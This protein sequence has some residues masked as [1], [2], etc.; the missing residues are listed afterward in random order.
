MSE[1][2]KNAK[3]L[4]FETEIESDK[5]L[6]IK[7]EKISF[8]KV[9]FS[10]ILFLTSIFFCITIY[11]S[12]QIKIIN[13]ENKKLENENTRIQEYIKQKDKIN[14]F[15]PSNDLIYKKKEHVENILDAIFYPYT[16]DIITSLDE[17]EFLRDIFGKVSIRLEY[18]SSIHG[19][20]NDIF[21][22]RTRKH[23]HQLVLIKTKKGNRFGGYTSENFEMN[24]LA[25]LTMDVDKFDNTAFLFNL[26]SKKVYN[27]KKDKIA[28]YCDDSFFIQFGDGDILIWNNFLQGKSLSMFPENY[29]NENC[30]KGEL[31]GG[32]FKFEIEELEI[33][34]VGFFRTDFKDE[35]NITGRFGNTPDGVF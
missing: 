18:K 7:K 30:E 17:L 33:F 12:I 14:I 4:N 1:E 28:I 5:K 15:S 3:F 24:K 8:I 9:F 10:T 23:N 6:E 11:T 29:G 35:F 16:S 27:V 25:E 19:D 34:H 2:T 20:K 22:N 31:T 21:H 13:S 26:D 32:E